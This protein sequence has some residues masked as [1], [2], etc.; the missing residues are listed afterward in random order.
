MRLELMTRENSTN[1]QQ[2][3]LT[4][5]LVGCGAAYQLFQFAQL[6]EAMLRTLHLW[7]GRPFTCLHEPG[8][9]WPDRH[10]MAGCLAFRRRHDEETD[11]NPTIPAGLWRLGIG[12]HAGDRP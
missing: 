1:E 10:T 11:F 12:N 6:R 3:P 5:T 9:E 4:I 2:I 8:K 7:I